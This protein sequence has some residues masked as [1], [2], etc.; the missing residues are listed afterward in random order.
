MCLC[1]FV[2]LTAA[3]AVFFSP[4]FFFVL[5]LHISHKFDRKSHSF[6]A[7][8][9]LN[10][11]AFQIQ[12]IMSWIPSRMWYFICAFYENQNV[13][14]YDKWQHLNLELTI[15]CKIVN[16]L[17]CRFIESQKNDD[18]NSNATYTGV[19][20]T[21]EANESDRDTEHRR[22]IH[23]FLHPFKELGKSLSCTFKCTYK[24]NK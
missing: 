5:S 17:F 20:R 1:S 13:Y 15:E 4:Y 12:N 2:H 9:V 3:S 10:W 21:F 7:K 22:W 16:S 23:S 18:I 6:C 8:G 24:L 14:L 11:P 19:R